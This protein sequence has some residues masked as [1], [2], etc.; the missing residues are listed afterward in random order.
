MK[1][2]VKYELNFFADLLE[3]ELESYK[4][5]FD[6]STLE[7]PGLVEWDAETH[8]RLLADT[9]VNWA[10]RGHL[11]P[12]KEQGTCGA[13]VPFSMTTA[14]EALV[15][16]K[17]TAENGGVLVKPV[18]LSEQHMLDCGKKDAVNVS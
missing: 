12:V 9:P 11:T 2:D 7:N 13:C 1:G 5:N 18:R 15:S 17:K 10:E 6:D 14:I 4:G 8:G 16:I 3:E